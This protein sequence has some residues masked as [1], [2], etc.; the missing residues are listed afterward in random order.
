MGGGF[1]IICW[2]TATF[3]LHGI[4]DGWFNG[5]LYRGN[6]FSDAVCE[7]FRRICHFDTLFTVTL[8]V[9]IILSVLFMIY[10]FGLQQ[11]LRDFYNE[12]RFIFLKFAIILSLGTGVT[13][14]CHLILKQQPACVQWSATGFRSITNTWR[15]P[16]NDLL[17][18]VIICSTL[19]K[20]HVARAW[21]RSTAALAF[22]LVYSICIVCSGY[23]AVSQVIVTCAIGAWVILLVGFIPPAA[24]PF[25]Q[26][27]VVIVDSV[28]FGV[29]YRVYHWD[30]I[31]RSTMHL[32]VRG[33]LT[34]CIS[35]YLFVSYAMTRKNF[36]WRKV[37]W[38]EKVRDTDDGS[39]DDA[40]IPRMADQK[41]VAI[42]FRTVLKRDLIETLVMAVVFMIGNYLLHEKGSY[43]FFS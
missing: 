22:I 2:M 32:A 1:D 16:D 31:M 6:K 20:A 36:E 24:V 8:E 17:V 28:L 18:V 10:G 29:N 7:T 14:A 3:Y 27:F 42:E 25:V 12:L 26:G 19:A 15:T 37:K 35:I 43:V 40:L 21:I 30:Y 34:I 41:S 13:A 4:S 11:K 5:C 23:A 38:Y 39:G 33:I 9:M